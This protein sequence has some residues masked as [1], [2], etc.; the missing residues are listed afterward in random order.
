LNSRCPESYESLKEAYQIQVKAKNDEDNERDLRGRRNI[1]GLIMPLELKT[2]YRIV[3]LPQR[4]AEVIDVDRSSAALHT[5]ENVQPSADPKLE[6]SQSSNMASTFVALMQLLY[7]GYKLGRGTGD[8]FERY[9]YSAYVLTVVPYLI[10]SF[11]NLVGNLATPIYPS[12]YLIGTPAMDEAQRRGY[13]LEGHIGCIS[14]ESL[15]DSD[16]GEQQGYTVMPCHALDEDKDESRDSTTDRSLHPPVKI[17]FGKSCKE[18]H[19][20]KL[21][22]NSGKPQ[23]PDDL[24]L[25]VFKLAALFLTINTPIIPLIYIHYNYPAPK[26]WQTKLGY[27]MAY[28]R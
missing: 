14:H 24:K 20:G 26:E 4:Y 18:A 25:V 21:R 13:V 22:V 6:L 2:G 3:A 15:L 10:M 11:V 23:Q 19:A 5:G 16:A 12:I 27:P 17:C 7:A 8:G 9:G 1:S 28:L